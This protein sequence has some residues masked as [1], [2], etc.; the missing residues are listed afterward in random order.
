MAC[1]I[2]TNSNHPA[3]IKQGVMKTIQTHAESICSNEC[4]LKKEI[5]N[6]VNDFSNNRNSNHYIHKTSKMRNANNDNEN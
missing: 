5:C 4:Y 3:Y 2:N 6:I 1:Y